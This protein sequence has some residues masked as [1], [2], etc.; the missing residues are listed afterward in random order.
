RHA[1]PLGPLCARPR[2]AS[3]PDSVPAEER[4]LPH[5]DKRGRW[6]MSDDL[7]AAVAAGVVGSEE[8]FRTLLESVVEVS[9]AI[10]SAKAASIFLLDEETDELVFDAIAGYGAETLLG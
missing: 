2:Q 1:A 5:F 7:K 4:P 8:S 3:R 6:E 9:R 10:F